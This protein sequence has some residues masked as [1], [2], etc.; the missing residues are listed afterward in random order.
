VQVSPRGGPRVLTAYTSDFEFVFHR[1][2]DMATIAAA[3][4]DGTILATGGVDGTVRLWSLETGDAITAFSP[5]TQAVLS[6]GWLPDGSGLVSMGLFG[7]VHFIDSVQRAERVRQ[8][9]QASAPVESE[10]A[11]SSQ[12]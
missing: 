4:P 11:G 6:L 7:E 1:H 12:Q 8:S 9:V 10:P 3:S 2:R 5:H